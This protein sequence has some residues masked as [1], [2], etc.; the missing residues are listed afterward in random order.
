[1][2]RAGLLAGLL[3]GIQ[4]QGWTE[5]CVAD[6]SAIWAG[7]LLQH[8]R[9]KWVWASIVDVKSVSFGN[10]LVC[11]DLPS[12][13]V[14]LD[15][16]IVAQNHDVD[17]DIRFDLQLRL[18]DCFAESGCECGGFSLQLDYGRLSRKR[19]GIHGIVHSTLVLS[20]FM[21]AFMRLIHT[22]RVCHLDVAC[23]VNRLRDRS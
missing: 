10:A 8:S 17:Q 4:V 1:M 23:R 21:I 11:D 12:F 22:H 19:G 16:I 13:S 14:Y 2:D 3:S 18:G 7:H 20:M 15:L 5:P 6:A 9:I